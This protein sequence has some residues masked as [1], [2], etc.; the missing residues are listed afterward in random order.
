MGLSP[1]DGAELNAAIQTALMSRT[2]DLTLDPEYQTTVHFEALWGKQAQA[3]ID[4]VNGMM[5]Q[6]RRYSQADYDELLPFV[7]QNA[8][9]ANMVL[10]FARRARR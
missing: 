2:V 3:N 5:R 1:W 6:L 4:A 10:A 9:V 8:E 7:N